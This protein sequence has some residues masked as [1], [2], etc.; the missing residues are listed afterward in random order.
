MAIAYG[1]R[2]DAS[3][4]GPIARGQI[5]EIRR[6]LTEEYGR[7]RRVVR[8]H[9]GCASGLAEERLYESDGV[10]RDMVLVFRDDFAGR[11]QMPTQPSPGLCDCGA[12]IPGWWS[13]CYRS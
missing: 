11:A 13:Y 2:Y 12:A 3:L 8:H 7:A 9:L 5:R 10:V 6:R 4:Y 1:T